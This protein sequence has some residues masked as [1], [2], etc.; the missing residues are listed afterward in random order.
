MPIVWMSLVS[1]DRHLLELGK[2]G[3]ADILSVDGF[4]ALQQGN[5]F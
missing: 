2:T 3:N 4:L 5:G 1:G